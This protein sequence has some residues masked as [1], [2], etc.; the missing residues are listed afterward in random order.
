MRVRLKRFLALLLA[1]AILA[2]FCSVT[3][4]AGEVAKGTNGKT[5]YLSWSY[6]SDIDL[7]MQVNELEAETEY[8]A[9]LGFSGNPI[10]S[11]AHNSICSASLYGS[12]DA[13]RITAERIYVG[14]VSGEKNITGNEFIVQWASN[15]GIIDKHEELLAEGYFT[16]IKFKTKSAIKSEDLPGLFKV[17]ARLSSGEDTNIGD[18]VLD[19]KGLFTIVEC[20]AFA[21]EPKSGVTFYDTDNAAAVKAKLS[22]KFIDKNGTSTNVEAVDDVII[23][24]PA[25]G[26]KAGENTINA[27]YQGYSCDVVIDVVAD[28][29]TG[30]EVKHNPTTMSYTRGQTLDLD[31][32][33][34]FAVYKSNTKK[35]LGSGTYSTDPAKNSRLTVAANNGRP[36]T[37]KVGGFTDTT[38]PLTVNPANLADAQIADIDSIQYQYGAEIEPTPEITLNGDTLVNGTDYQLTYVDNINVGNATLTATG[39]GTEYTGTKTKD[40]QITKATDDLTLKVNNED[41]NAVTITYGDALTFTGNGAAINEDT[42]SETKIQYKTETGTYADFDY[43]TVLDA[44]TYYFK[45]IRFDTQNVAAAES[46]N[47]VVVTIN[48][49]NINDVTIAAISDQTYT[50]SPLTPDVTATHG[51]KKLDKDTDYTLKYSYNLDVTSESNPTSVTVTGKG[52]YYGERTVTF[53]IKP[54][55]LSVTYYNFSKLKDGVE[56]VTYTGLPITPDVDDE[57]TASGVTLKEGEDYTVT[58][59]DNTNAGTGKITVTPVDGRNYTFNEFTVDFTINPVQIKITSSQYDWVPYVDGDKIKGHD[60]DGGGQQSPYFGY[61]GYPHGIKLQ[62]KDD[63]LVNGI[64][65]ETLVRITYT[66]ETTRTNAGGYATQMKFELKED[67]KTNY[68]LLDGSDNVVQ[69]RPLSKAWS[70]HKADLQPTIGTV[71]TL[72]VLC[73]KLVETGSKQECT[74]DLS[75]LGA[76]PKTIDVLEKSE[77]DYTGLDDTNKSNIKF[78]GVAAKAENTTGSIKLKLTFDNYNDYELTIPVNYINK[79]LVSD[80]LSMENIEVVYGQSYA[81]VLKLNGEVVTD[82]ELY[83]ITYTGE[84]GQ[85]VAEPKNAGT[86]TIKATYEDGIEDG[87]YPGHIG[88]KTATLT[89]TKKSLTANVTHGDITYGAEV[90]TDGYQVKFTGLV[91]NE[92]L[93]LGTDYTVGTTYTNGADAKDYGFTITLIDTSDVAKNYTIEAKDVTGT[94]TVN[95]KSLQGATVT[96]NDENPIIYDGTAKTPGVTVTLG[97]TALKPTDYTLKYENNTNAGTATITVKGTGNYTGTVEKTFEIKKATPTLAITGVKQDATYTG[98][99]FSNTYVQTNNNPSDLEV[100]Y[101]YYLQSDAACTTQ[102][103]PIDAGSYKVRISFAGNDNYN[104]VE[105]TATVDFT[106]GKANHPIS[107]TAAS[108]TYTGAVYSEKNITVTPDCEVTFTYYASETSTDSIARPTDV[109]TYW[110]VASYAGTNNYNSSTSARVS[111]SIT[112]ATPPTPTEVKVDGEDKTLKDLE[113]SM[114]KDLGTIEGSFTW[115]DSDGK[116]LPSDTKIEA[117]KEYEWIFTPSSSNY[118]PISGKTTPYVRDD[119]SWLP[120]VINGGTTFSFRDVTRYDYFYNA[121]KWAAENGIASGTSRYTFSPDAVCTRAQTVTFLWR[122]A[123]SPMP[124]Y[125]IS[126]FTDVNYG[127]YYYNAVLWAVEQ[128]ITTG[129][130]ATTFGPDKTVTRGQVATFLYRAASAVKPNITNPFTDVKSTAYNY[131]AILWAYDNRITT[132]T[133]TTTFS[134]DAVCTRAQIVTFLYRFYQGR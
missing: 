112:K 118:A 129:L 19:N 13:E 125:R 59:S 99:R 36:I 120:G 122:A 43:D 104:A 41:S 74:Y 65:L 1:A 3:V 69:E 10:D 84:D 23:A 79:L 124:S 101:E 9:R 4:F 18:G 52:N 80:K 132:G 93:T 32:L 123:G 95:P 64:K 89:I 67:Y 29:M 66:S 77:F 2:S 75:W 111:F 134:P 55:W 92:T 91:K 37:V 35:E 30:I 113:D 106:I 87:V 70:I 133:S 54:Q 5:I 102:V 21:A 96:L 44:D 116:E 40:F 110:V 97:E 114:R 72:N 126:P 34:V 105:P 71:P 26:L 109:G 73:D 81:P 12:F 24:L 17:N 22:Y 33:K 27:T 117:N 107:I 31:G 47:E 56:A 61:D 100:T 128:G 57:I 83:K 108:V 68:Q 38:G 50:G 46:T 78:T 103:N 82:K 39:I 76:T 119:L 15:N 48:R 6:Y 60:S 25:E 62:F 11:G 16:A 58:Y 20:P 131:D 130:T 53:T 94:L 42:T 14:D 98:E 127:D 45:A 28:E 7:T 121:V 88:E 49:K 8:Y 63:A 86:Y 85:P 115:R 90:P 51:S